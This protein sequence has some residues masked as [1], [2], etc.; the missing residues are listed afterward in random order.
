MSP[1]I[2]NY[3]VSK[4]HKRLTGISALSAA[5]LSAAERDVG[6][7]SNPVVSTVFKRRHYLGAKTLPIAHDRNPP[8]GQLFLV[9][10]ALLHLDGI[11]HTSFRTSVFA[12]QCVSRQMQGPY[13]CLRQEAGAY[14]RFPRR[15]IFQSRLPQFLRP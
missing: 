8:P 13:D 7:A 2:N 1:S 4:Y 10:S 6:L 12:D 9:Q 3:I 14:L 15:Y 5:E 11:P